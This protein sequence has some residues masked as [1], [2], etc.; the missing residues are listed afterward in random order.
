[1]KFWRKL[2]YKVGEHVRSCWGWRM[3]GSSLQSAAQE[4]SGGWW[5]CYE[6][7]MVFSLKNNIKRLVKCWQF[8]RM[9]DDST[10]VLI[11]TSV[12]VWQL[13]F[14]MFKNERKKK[15]VKMTT[16][17]GMSKNLRKKTSSPVLSEYGWRKNLLNFETS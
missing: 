10:W 2:N 5:K 7:K 13:Y 9:V 12:Y 4:N 16:G 6:N 8:L 14:K 1:M 17:I 15:N 11:S 3:E